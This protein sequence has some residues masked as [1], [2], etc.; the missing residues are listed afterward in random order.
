LMFDRFS[1]A[2]S[3]VPER[4]PGEPELTD[5]VKMYEA[6]AGRAVNDIYWYELLAGVRYCAIVVRIMNRMVDRGQM[7]ADNNIWLDNPATTVTEELLTL[8]P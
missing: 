2:S 4:L 6:H 1:H 8:V 5:Q 3:G 7:P